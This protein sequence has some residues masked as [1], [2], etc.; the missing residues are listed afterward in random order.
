MKSVIKSS[1]SSFPVP[2]SSTRPETFEQLHDFMPSRHL[3]TSA[4][5]LISASFLPVQPLA[6]SPLFPFSSCSLFFPSFLPRFLAHLLT[7]TRLPAVVLRSNLPRL[8]NL[9][10]WLII[11]RSEYHQALHTPSHAS[12]EPFF[13]IERTCT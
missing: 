9:V 3:D 4:L 13:V 11:R 5:S 6:D 2:S 1:A 12:S 8:P 7:H 10:K